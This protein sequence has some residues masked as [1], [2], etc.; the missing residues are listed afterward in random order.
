MRRESRK[1][2]A[3]HNGPQDRPRA[4]REIS[5]SAR[6]SADR[7]ADGKAIIVLSAGG[8]SMDVTSVVDVTSFV[9]T[10]AELLAALQSR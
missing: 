9:T 8:R 7:H 4:S 3:F 6:P 5:F 1:A 2:T 10:P